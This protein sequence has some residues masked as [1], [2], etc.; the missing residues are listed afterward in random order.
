MRERRRNK[1]GW[2]SYFGT[3]FFGVR[4][5]PVFENALNMLVGAVFPN[6]QRGTFTGD[7][8]FT[9]GKN[10][11]FLSDDRF[12]RAVERHAGTEVERSIIWRTAVLCWAARNGLRREGDFV[13]CGCYMGT[14]A[15]VVADVLDFAELDRTYWLYDLFEYPEGSKHTH[16]PGM[17]A[18]L[19]EATKQRFGDLENVRV[20]RGAVPAVLEGQSADRIAFLHIDM[21]NAAAEIGALDALFDRVSP[22]G[23]VVLDDYGYQGYVEQRDAERAWFAARGYDVIELPTSQGLVVK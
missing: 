3:A 14:S 13:E 23:I 6:W 5:R 19:F 8:L 4:D 22:G 17:G 10:L 7:N 1:E 16:M 20:I 11:S 21:N 9:F 15:R 18:G 2:P 12:M